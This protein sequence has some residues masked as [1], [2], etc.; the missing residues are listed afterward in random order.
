MAHTSLWRPPG[1]IAW[2]TPENRSSSSSSSSSPSVSGTMHR[3][4]ARDRPAR[5]DRLLHI[6]ACSLAITFHYWTFR[7]TMTNAPKRTYGGNTAGFIERR[8]SR[9]AALLA[10]SDESRVFTS[11]C[12]DLWQSN[13][14]VCH[15]PSSPAAADLFIFLSPLFDCKFPA[16]SSFREEN[17]SGLLSWMACCRHFVH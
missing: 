3:R 7:W 6:C 5:R 8:A 14:S 9:N 1:S 15:S 2:R 12:V 4:P 13:T 11:G 16:A 10:D 17:K